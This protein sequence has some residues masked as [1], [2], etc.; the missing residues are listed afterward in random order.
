MDSGL[1]IAIFHLDKPINIEVGSFGRYEFAPG[2][3]F[4]AG[5]A[6]KNMTSRLDRHAS[7][8]KP[9]RWHID[10]LSIHATMLGAIVLE[11]FDITECELAEELALLYQRAILRFG[12][13]DCKCSGHLFYMAEI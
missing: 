7:C 5:S 11:D 10:Y 13:S 3:Y 9:L 8:E 12:A 2:Y 6:K 1:Y 4:Y